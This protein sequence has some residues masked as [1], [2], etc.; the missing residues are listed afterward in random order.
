MIKNYLW[1]K[2]KKLD[3][4][5]MPPVAPVL[6]PVRGYVTIADSN[7][8]EIQ[9]IQSTVN[10]TELLGE[11]PHA[12][13]FYHPVWLK[14]Y[15][16]MYKHHGGNAYHKFDKSGR[17]VYYE[18]IGLHK[19][20]ELVSQSEGWQNYHILGQEMMERVLLKEANDRKPEG[21]DDIDKIVVVMDCKGMG[22]HQLYLPALQLIKGVSEMDQEFYPERLAKLYVVNAPWMF[23]SIWNVIKL[24]LDDNMLSKI[25]IL[26]SEFLSEI[27]KDI[28]LDSLPKFLGGNCTCDHLKGGCVPV[29]AEVIK[30]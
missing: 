4:V 30:D 20:K 3:T 23:T 22:F 8:T 7:F 29:P 21:S 28:H 14:K 16:Q 24:W 18:R 10:E 12:D 11:Y 19:A 2:E 5:R 6:T 9:E 17:P 27:E 15:K 13:D 26:G 1:R 25:S